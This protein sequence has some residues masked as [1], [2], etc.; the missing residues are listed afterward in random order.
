MNDRIRIPKPEPK[1]QRGRK[2]E[3][4][5]RSMKQGSV[6]LFKCHISIVKRKLDYFIYARKTFDTWFYSSYDGQDRH[7]N[8][9]CYIYRAMDY[10]DMERVNRLDGRER[11]NFF[12][13]RD[14]T[15]DPM[16]NL[17]A[18]Y[19]AEGREWPGA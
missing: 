19:K 6:K 13:N 7:G 2:P 11:F 4:D 15:H 16:E 3:F 10:E 18:R 1:P 17:K 12:T 8:N 14:M 9:I 5:F